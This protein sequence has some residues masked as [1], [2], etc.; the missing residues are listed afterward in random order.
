[1]PDTVDFQTTEALTAHPQLSRMQLPAAPRTY[2]AE[3]SARALVV[4]LQAGGEALP[5]SGGRT[6]E[7][8]AGRP[9][10][11]C[12]PGAAVDASGRDA[13]CPGCRADRRSRPRSPTAWTAR[14]STQAPA[15]AVLAAAGHGVPARTRA[16][17]LRRPRPADLHQKPSPPERRSTALDELMSGYDRSLEAG[18]RAPTSSLASQPSPTETGSIASGRSG[19]WQHRGHPE[20]TVKPRY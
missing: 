14:S 20:C 13:W 9:P 8:Q 2:A 16:S 19:S 6:A 12:A 4:E 10:A 1:M 3:L 5:A 15:G 7:P 11:A 17:G 18:L